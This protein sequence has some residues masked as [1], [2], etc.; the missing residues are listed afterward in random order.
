MASTGEK[1]YMRLR[2]EK[3]DE[4]SR[5]RALIGTVRGGMVGVRGGS[6][7]IGRSREVGEKGLRYWLLL[8]IE[9]EAFSE[10][11]SA[12]PD[13]AAL[14]GEELVFVLSAVFFADDNLPRIGRRGRV[15]W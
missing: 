11:T 2:P 14:G 3:D 7:A 4:G 13:R 6:R 10:D 15:W 5:E 12:G 9:A 1:I 8:R